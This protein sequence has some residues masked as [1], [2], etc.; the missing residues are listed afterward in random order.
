MQLYDCK[1]R[2]LGSLSNEVRKRQVTAAEIAVLHR[3]HGADAVLDVKRVGEVKKRTDRSERARL[4]GI[5]RGG[6]DASGKNRLSGIAFIDSILGVGAPL[7]NEY[8][9]PEIV[10]PEA[11]NVDPEDGEEIVLDGAEV[12]TEEAQ[13]TDPVPVVPVEPIRR[14]RVAKPVDAL[15]E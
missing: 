12:P 10:L 8:V 9:P 13:S 15:T 2:L 5:Y 7:P 11:F 6:P 3:V 14:T 1:V 4:T